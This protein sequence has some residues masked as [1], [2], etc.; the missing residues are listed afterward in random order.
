MA[1]PLPVNLLFAGTGAVLLISGIGGETLG[2]VLKGNFGLVK[3]ETTGDTGVSGG[4]ASAANTEA[5][6]GTGTGEDAPSPT[7][8]SSATL[9][10]P[11]TRIGRNGPTRKQQA[12]G[13]ARVLLEEG[14]RNPTNE[15]IEIA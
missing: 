2:E 11:P 15:Q 14:I 8:F 4:L 13:I 3:T 5:A 1:R 10:P 7:V 6:A 12:E 9:A